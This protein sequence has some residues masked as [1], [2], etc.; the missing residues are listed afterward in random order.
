MMEYKSSRG[1]DSLVALSASVCFMLLLVHLGWVNL[2]KLRCGWYHV[3][4]LNCGVFRWK[5]IEF[6]LIV[7]R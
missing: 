5:V 1:M 4:D 7:C 2:A 3:I 6:A